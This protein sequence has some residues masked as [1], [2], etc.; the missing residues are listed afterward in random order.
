MYVSKPINLYDAMTA[1]CSP[2]VK[3]KLFADINAENGK[4][5][6]RLFRLLA[7]KLIRSLRH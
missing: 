7:K 2:T 3:L 5:A 6:I 4:E 1:S